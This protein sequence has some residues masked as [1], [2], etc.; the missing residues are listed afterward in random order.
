[1]AKKKGQA[2]KSQPWV[3]VVAALVV[4]S[5]ELTEIKLIHGEKV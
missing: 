3:V 5:R 1:M 2:R 4:C